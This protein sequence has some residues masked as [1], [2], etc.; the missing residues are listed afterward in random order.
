MLALLF[1]F[2]FCHQFQW[3]YCDLRLYFSLDARLGSKKEDSPVLF[4]LRPPV[5]FI[6]KIAAKA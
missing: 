1:S 4:R 2:L 5:N 6:D 3:D